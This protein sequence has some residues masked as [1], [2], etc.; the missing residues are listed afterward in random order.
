MTSVFVML[1]VLLLAFSEAREPYQPRRQ[2]EVIG[3]ARE[4]A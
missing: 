3:G 4:V 2:F 1:L